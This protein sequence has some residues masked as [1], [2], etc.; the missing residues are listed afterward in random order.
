M[1]NLYIWPCF[2]PYFM[3]CGYTFCTECL[4]DEITKINVNNKSTMICLMRD[5]SMVLYFSFSQQ[6]SIGV[7]TLEKIYKDFTRSTVEIIKKENIN[8]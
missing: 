8:D 3:K 4:G 1:F 7:N 5:C 2:V 6:Y